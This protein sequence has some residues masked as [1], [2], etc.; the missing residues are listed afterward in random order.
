MPCLGLGL[1]I[2][3]YRPILPAGDGFGPELILNGGF[4]SDTVWTKGAGFTI[5]LGRASRVPDAS[6]SGLSQPIAFVAGR[7]YRVVFTVSNYAAGLFAAQ[8][9]GGTTRNGT[10]RTANGTY[11][12]TLLANTGNISFRIFASNVTQGDLDSIS[13]REVL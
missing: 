11:T 10:S 4:D 13:V 6:S 9:T 8:F 5:A 1:A 3:A 2:P 7:S 12:E